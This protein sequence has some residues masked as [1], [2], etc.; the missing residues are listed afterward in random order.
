MGICGGKRY[1]SIL[2][3]TRRDDFNGDESVPSDIYWTDQ[4]EWIAPLHRIAPTNTL[5][6]R[7]VKFIPSLLMKGASRQYLLCSALSI[8]ERGADKRLGRTW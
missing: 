8:S 2:S 5:V 6:D 4:P 1:G 3:P 7:E